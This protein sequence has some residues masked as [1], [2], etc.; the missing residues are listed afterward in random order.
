M[1]MKILKQA[2]SLIGVTREEA[3][4]TII[5]EQL[6]TLQEQARMIELQ[7]QAIRSLKK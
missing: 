2:A 7:K 3:E 1:N 5:A 6:L 4:K